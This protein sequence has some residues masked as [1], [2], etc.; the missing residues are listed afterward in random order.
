MW[1]AQRITGDDSGKVYAPV[2]EADS[3]KEHLLF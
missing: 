2:K 1:S 3:I